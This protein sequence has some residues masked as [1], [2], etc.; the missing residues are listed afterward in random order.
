M[1]F[2][3]NMQKFCNLSEVSVGENIIN[4]ITRMVSMEIVGKQSR[5]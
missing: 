5:E 3:H 1:C 2:L 4:L